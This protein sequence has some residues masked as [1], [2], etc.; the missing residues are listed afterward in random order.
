V[1]T[2]RV[3][4]TATAVIPPELSY[5]GSPL[6][7]D[8]DDDA[9]GA[10]HRVDRPTADQH[11]KR[12]GDGDGQRQQLRGQRERQLVIGKATQT[13]WKMIRRK[14]VIRLLGSRAWRGPGDGA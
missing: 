8:G 2:L 13:P 3:S 12:S 14:E 10:G 4:S 9:G 11:R 1:T 7:A 6:T 5:T